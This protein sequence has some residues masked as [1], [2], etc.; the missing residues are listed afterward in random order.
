MSNLIEFH[1]F[2][3]L[4]QLKIIHPLLFNRTKPALLELINSEIAYK[5]EK[6]FLYVEK[7][8][9]SNNQLMV[10]NQGMLKKYAE[11]NLF[12]E[13]KKRKDGIFVEQ[14][15]FSLAAGFS[16]IFATVIAFSFQQKYGNFTMPFFVALI[17]SYMLKDRIKE[18]SRFYL[19]NK[20]GKRYFDH[21][22]NISTHDNQ[23]GWI[24]ES[25]DFVSESN[26]PQEVEKI[27]NRSSILEANHRA[28]R[29][30]VI[31][32]RTLMQLNRESI[33]ANS[34]YPIAGVNKIMRLN[35]SSLIQKMDNSEFP[36]Y[37]PD[38]EEGFVMVPGEKIYYLNMIVQIKNL[39]HSEY[40]R[41]RIVF[42]REGI[43]KI[44]KFEN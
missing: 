43:H 33:D 14:F 31:L 5:K 44:E 39:E 13:V 28:N 19:A 34:E 27:R 21:K 29:E 41:Y 30:R 1:T 24:K 18:L 25:M 42:N 16:M 32:Y 11:S 6:E 9:L 4:H 37:Y 20:M 36:L 12:L 15:V 3:L 22:I 7:N 2:R 38:A 23:I 10:F 17:V 8:S 40:R 35:I 26:V